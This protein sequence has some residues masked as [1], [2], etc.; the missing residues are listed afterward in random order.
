MQ[1]QN[2][3]ATFALSLALSLLWQRSPKRNTLS[4]IVFWTWKRAAT[5]LLWAMTLSDAACGFVKVAQA[6]TAAPK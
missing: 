2:I 4:G 3:T 6:A 5:G 1:E